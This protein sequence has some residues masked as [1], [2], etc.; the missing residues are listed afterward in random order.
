[1]KVRLKPGYYISRDGHKKT[2]SHYWSDR[3]YSAN[4]ELESEEWKTTIKKWTKEKVIPIFEGSL[5]SKKKARAKILEILNKD[6]GQ[7]RYS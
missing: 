5:P 6:C 3:D 7:E 2:V 4:L 1:M